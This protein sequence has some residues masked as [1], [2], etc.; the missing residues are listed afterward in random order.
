MCSQPVS[1]FWPTA[2]EPL[3]T[4]ARYV[5]SVRWENPFSSVQTNLLASVGMMVLD[6][7]MIPISTSKSS[8][9]LMACVTTAGVQ[10]ECSGKVLDRRLRTSN[11][12]VLGQVAF[13]QSLNARHAAETS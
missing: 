11:H 5:E 13:T 8:S 10:E 4:T 6:S 7:S 1:G 2:L 3:G 9:R 12:D